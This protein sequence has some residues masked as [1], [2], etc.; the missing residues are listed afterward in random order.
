MDKLNRL[1][2]TVLLLVALALLLTTAANCTTQKNE[3]KVNWLYDWNEAL[4]KAQN[5]GKPIMIDFYADWCTPCK[6]L[7]SDTYSDEELGAFLN[8]NFVSLKSNVDKS[9]LYKNYPDIQYLPTIVFT[10]PEGIEIERMVGYRTPDRFY[11][12][13]QAILSQWGSQP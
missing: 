9:D 2:K 13:V 4:S 12:D 7:D 3:S 10:S 1:G 11:Q 5:E 8:D 6:R